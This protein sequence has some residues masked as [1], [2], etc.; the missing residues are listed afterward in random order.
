[1]PPG[2][3]EELWRYMT[4]EQFL[5]ILVT[6][7]LFFPRVDRFNDPYEGFKPK[8]IK[9]MQRE[10]AN[11]VRNDPNVEVMEIYD[12]DSQE[13]FLE[14]WRKYVMCSC[15]HMNTSESMAMWERYYLRNSGIAIKTTTENL[16]VSLSDEYDVFIG[17]IKYSDTQNYEFTYLFH[18]IFTEGLQESQHKKVIYYPYFLKRKAFEY[19]NEVRII[20]D[21]EAAVINYFNC[22]F[23]GSATPNDLASLINSGFPDIWEDGVSLGIDIEVL[24]DEVVIS[25]LADS[26]VAN[27]IE[28]VVRQYG[29]DFDVNQSELLALP[30]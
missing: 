18:Y 28:S 25:P 11:Q 1:M 4:Y 19:E 8:S 27:T 24:I 26:W 7:S 17:K 16:K 6:G 2:D 29:Y 23:P 13:K 12:G 10:S 30:V 5:N 3:K 14:N 9:N 22:K 20:I 21:S 15:W